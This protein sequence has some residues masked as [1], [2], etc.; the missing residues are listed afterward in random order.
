MP[1]YGKNLAPQEVTALVA[2]C[3]RYGR[4][5]CLRPATRLGDDWSD[6]VMAR[7]ME[8]WSIG[9]LGFKCITP[10]LQYS[11]LSTY[12]RVTWILQRRRS[13]F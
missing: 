13:A 4:P 3:R 10:L 5:M 11:G 1:A 6:E 12:E 7:K 2:S 8:C 9:V